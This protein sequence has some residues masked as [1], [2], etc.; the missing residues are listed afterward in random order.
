MSWQQEGLRIRVVATCP[1]TFPCLFPAPCQ[2]VQGR[3]ADGPSCA[4]GPV[5]TPQA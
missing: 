2:Q 5:G 4:A 3:D 1:S